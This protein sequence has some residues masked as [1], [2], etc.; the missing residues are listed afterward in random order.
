MNPTIKI[1]IEIFL[2]VVGLVTATVVTMA[3]IKEAKVR[4]SDPLFKPNPKRC[5]EERDRILSLEGQNKV[6]ATR[7]DNVDE[8]IKDLKVGQAKILDLHLTR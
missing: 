1:I 7:F 2:G 3:K 6:W 5:Q 4:K 8:G